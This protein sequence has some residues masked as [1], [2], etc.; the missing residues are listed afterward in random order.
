MLQIGFKFIIITET[1]PQEIYLLPQFSIKHTK[2]Q[3][4]TTVST[5]PCI[6]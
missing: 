1:A 3:P 6:I 2:K 5:I 4:D